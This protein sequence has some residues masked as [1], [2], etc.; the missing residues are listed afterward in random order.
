[1]I[2]Q[3]DKWGGKGPSTLEF[4]G[5][6]KGSNPK[7]MKITDK[8]S[9]EK[10]RQQQFPNAGNALG[11]DIGHSEDALVN[12]DLKGGTTKVISRGDRIKAFAD[13]FPCVEQSMKPTDKK[14]F[15]S[16]FVSITV[17]GITYTV[18]KGPSGWELKGTNTKTDPLAQ[19]GRYTY[20]KNCNEFKQRN[21]KNKTTT[22]VK[23]PLLIQRYK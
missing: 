23:D 5:A 10:I 21:T 18:D 14:N 17:D 4:Y 13:I 9:I 7:W 11:Q 22:L 2:D 12:V 19:S 8:N 1:M 6:R 16:E 15:A 20:F 3:K